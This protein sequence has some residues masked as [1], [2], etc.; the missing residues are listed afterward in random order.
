ML[1]CLFPPPFCPIDNHFSAERVGK[2]AGLAPSRLQ[3]SSTLGVKRLFVLAGF[4][5]EGKFDSVPESE[6]IVDDAKII[7]DDVL[8]GSQGSGDF[9]VLESFGNKFDDAVLP[10]AGVACSVTLDCKHNCLR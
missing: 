8:G 4:V 10:L 9:G 6:L 5:P 3:A 1:S 7:F 2:S